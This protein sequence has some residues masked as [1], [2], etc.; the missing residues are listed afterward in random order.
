MLFFNCSACLGLSLLSLL[1]LCYLEFCP[2]P[3]TPEMCQVSTLTL[4]CNLDAF[5]GKVGPEK[6]I[7]HKAKQTEVWKNNPGRMIGCPDSLP[8]IWSL[9]RHQ[10]ADVFQAE[11]SFQLQLNWL[12]S[13]PPKHHIGRFSP[14]VCS[15]QPSQCKL[16][17]HPISLSVYFSYN[18]KP[19]C[20]KWHFQ[21][22]WGFFEWWKL[23]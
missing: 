6:D 1:C 7:S 14:R 8:I 11:K 5:M 9:W 15:E 21:Y 20:R 22:I 10:K 4:L 23:E 17:N 13:V 18:E 12:P 19:R 2:F 16:Q 3:H